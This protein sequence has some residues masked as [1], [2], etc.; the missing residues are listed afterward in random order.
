MKCLATLSLVTAAFTG[1]P[2]SAHEHARLGWVESVATGIQGPE[3]IVEVAARDKAFSTL[4]TALKTANLAETLNGDGPFTVFAP[5]NEAFNAL[6]QGTLRATLRDSKRLAQILTY[7]VVP[8]RLT[9]QDVATRRTLDTVNGQ[10]LVVAV[11][12]GLQI[13][14]DVKVIKGDIEA[15]NGVIHVIDAVLIPAKQNIAEIAKAAHF[16][17]LLAALSAADLASVFASDDGSFTV[18]APTNEA[19]AKLGDEAIAALLEPRN[20]DLLTQILKYHVVKG[21]FY[22]DAVSANLFPETLAG[23]R[24]KANMGRQGVRLNESNVVRADIDATNGVIHVIDSVLVPPSL[25]ESLSSRLTAPTSTGFAA[26]DAMVTAIDIAVPLFNAGNAAAC[27]AV[28]QATA[29]NLLAFDAYELTA[30]ER[31]RLERGLK[32]QRGIDDRDGAWVL[33]E[34]F[35]SILRGRASGS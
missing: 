30:G 19:F 35:D 15:A 2:G 27:R 22:S 16:D 3:S 14:G 6:G 1:T 13:N 25:A 4:V 21:R 20:R 12:G 7:H 32:Q 17:T 5:T 31:Q 18:F 8:G 29:R 10:R 9:A 26:G 24:T 23:E 33:R 28:Y 34:A 11:R